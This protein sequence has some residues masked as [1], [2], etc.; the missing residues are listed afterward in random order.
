MKAPYIII[1]CVLVLASLIMAHNILTLYKQ[2]CRTPNKNIHKKIN[3]GEAKLVSDVLYIILV[4]IAAYFVD[5][6]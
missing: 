6:D 4:I 5:E 1:I 3:N 2:E